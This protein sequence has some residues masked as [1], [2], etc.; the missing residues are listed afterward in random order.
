[1]Q[2]KDDSTSFVVIT[3]AVVLALCWAGWMFYDEM[4]NY[5]RG[6]G[7]N[8]FDSFQECLGFLSFFSE[9]LECRGLWVEEE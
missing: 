2:E 7:M 9:W 6:Y 1:M 4:Y 8:G 5:W 3:I